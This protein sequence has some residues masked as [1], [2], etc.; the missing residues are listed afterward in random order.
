[1][2][3]EEAIKKEIKKLR[4]AAKDCYEGRAA[5]G[6]GYKGITDDLLRKGKRLEAEADKLQEILDG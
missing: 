2:K 1:M 6:R 5:L 3:S 4:E